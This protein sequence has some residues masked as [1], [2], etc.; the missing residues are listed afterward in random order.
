MT[1]KRHT[2][3]SRGGQ[4]P[5]KSCSIMFQWFLDLFL[6]ISTFLVI[7]F[8]PPFT[9]LPHSLP[10]PCHFGAV[11]EKGCERCRL[12]VSSLSESESALYTKRWVTS[13]TTSN[14]GELHSLSCKSTI[15]ALLPFFLLW[16]QCFSLYL[17]E[18]SVR[19]RWCETERR[20]LS[21]SLC[22]FLFS[23]SDLSWLMQQVCVRRGDWVCLGK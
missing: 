10:P 16:E 1:V 6:N 5:A 14:K 11:R 2:I 15:F 18:D 19:V 8:P 22:C 12:N 17:S 4:W 3:K 13:R 7:S 23:L 20:P 21:S 9:S